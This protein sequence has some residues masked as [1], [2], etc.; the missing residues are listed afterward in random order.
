MTPMMIPVF[1][2]DQRSLAAAAQHGFL[3]PPGM[4]YKPGTH[5]HKHTSPGAG[6]FSGKSGF[7]VWDME[8]LSAA[9]AGGA[10]GSTAV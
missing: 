3:F 4:S 10:S 9:L 6:L 5:T 7:R 8:K 2:H 1:P